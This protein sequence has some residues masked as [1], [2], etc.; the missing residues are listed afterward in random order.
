[1]TEYIIQKLSCPQFESQ[2]LTLDYTELCYVTHLT[3]PCTL[4][5]GGP[6]DELTGTNVDCVTICTSGCMVVTNGV[7][8]GPKCGGPNSWG[9]GAVGACISN[10]GGGCA[11]KTAKKMHNFLIYME[12]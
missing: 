5:G 7:P 2:L 12:F 1:M 11:V 6:Q 10:G 9:G 3:C 4:L 8:S